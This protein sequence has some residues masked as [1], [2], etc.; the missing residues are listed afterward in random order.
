MSR[1]LFLYLGCSLSATL[2]MILLFLGKPLWKNRLSKTWQ[3]YIWLLVII[4]LLVPFSPTPGVIGQRVE[5]EAG[6]Q[7]AV[8]PE[9]FPAEKP[10]QE[11]LGEPTPIEPNQDFE[12]NMDRMEERPL[13]L[14]SY[15][16]VLWLLPAAMMLMY[17]IISYYRYLRLVKKAS[18]PVTDPEIQKIC[19]QVETA[20]KQRQVTALYSCKAVVSP[21]VVGVRKPCIMLPSEEFSSSQLSYIFLHELTHW[22]RKDI[23]YKW[24]LQAAVCLH[25]YHPLVYLMRR[26]CDRACELACDEAV[27]R[28]LMPEQRK[29]YGDTLIASMRAG[30]GQARPAAALSMCESVHTLKERLGAIMQIRKSSRIQKAAACFFTLAV[31][32]AL[33]LL[34]GFSAEAMEKKIPQ[35][36]DT[37][38]QKVMA[39]DAAIQGS[40]SQGT[41][42]Q[43]VPAQSDKMQEAETQEQGKRG[44]SDPWLNDPKNPES[45]KWNHSFSVKSFLVGKYGIR[46]AWDNDPSLYDTT[47]VISLGQGDSLQVSF[48]EE[49]KGHADNP[50]VLE[51]IRLAILKQQ[52]W[53][54]KEDGKDRAWKSLIMENPVVVEVTGPYEESYDQLTLRFYEEGRIDYFVY[55]VAEASEETRLHMLKRTYEEKNVAYF[56]CMEDL[57][58]EAAR[59][60]YMQRAFEEDEI[61][62]FSILS[63]GAEGEVLEVFAKKAYE[64]ED[65]SFFSVC[66][67]AM[68]DEDRKPYAYQAYEDGRLSFFAVTADAFND[69][70]Q[71]ALAERAKQEGK[72]IFLYALPNRMQ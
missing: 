64:S 69:Q 66:T 50:Q 70:E 19:R 28:G 39:Q 40:M 15:L 38:T 21:M 5:W 37:A 67:Q 55:A 68:S 17:Q 59:L 53:E 1:L 56:S 31:S 41:V 6:R 36:P 65:I 13:H 71:S 4:R 16:W 58:P 12:Q 34:G 26:E 51:A 18:L 27:V 25:W 2:L 49:T 63:D 61:S 42:S 54:Q 44:V 52:S 62:F 24:L 22:K 32:G 10:Q 7:A 48:I 20:L 72:E 45:K 57:I 47:R 3:Y 33:L 8:L 14:I 35:Q 46:L 9:N 60:E 43:D 29:D 23:L 11:I 30:H